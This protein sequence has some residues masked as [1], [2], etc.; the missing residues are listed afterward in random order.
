MTVTEVQPIE[1]AKPVTSE[2]KKAKFVELS[3]KVVF[4]TFEGGFYAIDGD[5]GKKY[6]P[7]NLPEHAQKAGIKVAMQVEIKAGIMT[8]YNYGIPIEIQELTITDANPQDDNVM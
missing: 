7:L 3:G 2:P 6:L 1:T 8:I 4:K 5:D